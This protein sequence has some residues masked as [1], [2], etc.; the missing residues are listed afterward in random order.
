MAPF[1][2]PAENKEKE[3]KNELIIFT[4]DADRYSNDITKMS[5][6]FENYLEEMSLTLKEN[7]E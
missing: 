4:T 2:K 1:F 5:D 7:N 6:F 3:K